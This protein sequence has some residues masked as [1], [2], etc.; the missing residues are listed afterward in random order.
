[1]FDGADGAAGGVVAGGFVA[2]G[3]VVD[4]FVVG[5]VVVGGVVVD[6]FIVVGVVVGGVVVDGFIVAGVVVGGVAATGA[7]EGAVDSEGVSSGAPAEV[8]VFDCTADRSRTDDA[9]MVDSVD[10][11]VAVEATGA[12]SLGLLISLAVDD[13]AYPPKRGIYINNT[14][15][16][17]T[18]LF[19]IRTIHLFTLLT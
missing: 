17:I 11:S 5:S 19:F 12:V 2:G 14:I 1:M 6:G 13:R 16:T 15:R 10:S 8:E 4:G 7:S 18:I 9:G 3:V